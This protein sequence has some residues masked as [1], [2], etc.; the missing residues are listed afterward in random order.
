MRMSVED[1]RITITNNFKTTSKKH[2][3]N[4]LLQFYQKQR[5][6]AT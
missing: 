4:Y 6:V 3:K 5:I 2:S 1:I